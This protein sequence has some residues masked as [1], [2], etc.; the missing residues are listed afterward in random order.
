MIDQD[1]EQEVTVADQFVSVDND[2][3]FKC[4]LAPQARD[5][6][7]V[8]GWIEDGQH[9]IQHV[10]QPAL[11]WW[12]NVQ[13]NSMGL[14]ANQLIQQQQQRTLVLPD[15]QLYIQRVQLK[16]TNKSFR[17]QIKNLLDGQISLSSLSGRLFVT[18]EYNKTMLLVALSSILNGR[19]DF[20]LSEEE[21]PR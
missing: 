8:V 11:V 5:L 3:V 14:R 7:Q 21:F 2:A 15:G 17:C 4:Q 12:L 18:G 1:Y 16:D 19:M 9:L 10:S 6:F 13:Q 20:E